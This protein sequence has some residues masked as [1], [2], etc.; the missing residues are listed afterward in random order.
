MNSE[1]LSELR[2]KLT[3]RLRSG[4]AAP[5]IALEKLAKGEKV[6]KEFLEIAAKELNAAVELL[7]GKAASHQVTKHHVTRKYLLSFL[8]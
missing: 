8:V 3:P 2:N 1:I 6:P 7:G 4:Q 5:K